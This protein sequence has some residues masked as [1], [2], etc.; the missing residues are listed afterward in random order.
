M[1]ILTVGKPW[2]II[3]NF[4]WPILLSGLLQQLYN[5][6]DI[7]IVG[8]LM[9][10]NA[11]AAIGST[12]SLVSFILGFAQGAT[13]GM[14]LL[15]ANS[16]G[17]RNPQQVNRRFGVS[18]LL[19]MIISLTLM[20]VGVLLADEIL[21]LLG[22]PANIIVPAQ[23]Y[24]SIIFAGIPISMTF[25]FLSNMM[26]AIGN[27]R[28]PLIFLGISSLVNI[29]FN[30]IFI[31]FFH[32]GIAGSAL[33]TV[34]AQFVSAILCVYHIYRHVPLLY[35]HKPLHLTFKE[36]KVQLASGIPMGLQFSIIA[37]GAIL[38][39]RSLNQLGTEA[40]AAFS[41]ASKIDQISMLPMSALGTALGTYVAQNAGGQKY[42]RVLL[43]VK[44]T[45]KLSVLISVIITIVILLTSSQL[46]YLFISTPG[47]ELL[48]LTR[49]YFRLVTP[50]YVLLSG[51]FI[52][53]FTLQGL[54]YNLLPMVAGLIEL[55]MRALAAILLVGIWGY[56][57]ICLSAP[58]AWLGGI[59]TLIYRFWKAI[60]Q[61]DQMAQLQKRGEKI[62]ESL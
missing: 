4:G 33:A 20:L 23:T 13:A 42:Q 59:M 62:S 39:Q 32:W 17:S 50:W 25:N 28:T 60:R 38:V 21:E 22:T 27:S 52:L 3:L 18:A 5:F 55:L 46:T 14:G 8:Q 41:V 9:G 40:I 57:G 61:V 29:V 48:N 51:L 11:V 56:V 49:L 19:A 2:K 37:I 53:R 7:M 15:V 24:I 12:T 45:F 30:F 43:G 34:F 31:L 54:N 6:S 35:W 44:Q 47:Q 10:K 1:T 26:R 58:L 16:F 36:I